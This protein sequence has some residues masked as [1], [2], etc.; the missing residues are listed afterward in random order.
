MNNGWF[1][2]L[3]QVKSLIDFSYDNSYKQ[4]IDVAERQDYT[5]SF[6]NRC[7]PQLEAC[8]KSGSV[9][10]CKRANIFCNVDS[11]SIQYKL[12]MEADF[13]VYDIR[14][15][16]SG[17]RHNV[18]AHVEYL[19]NESIMAAIG[20]RSPYTLCSAIPGVFLDFHKTGD[21][22]YFPRYVSDMYLE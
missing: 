20:A 21:S 18:N 13:D 3:I 15:P 22:K 10:D 14:F 7:R 19:G 5:V 4:I 1:D 12:K 6:E 9:W 2:S 11:G 17:F 8:N 16:A